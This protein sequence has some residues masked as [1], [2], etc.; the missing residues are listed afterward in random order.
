MLF[1]THYC[2]C[3]LHLIVDTWQKR[4]NNY[5][6]SYWIQK[7]IS[8]FE[9]CIFLV[10]ICNKIFMLAERGFALLSDACIFV[11]VCIHL[12]PYTVTL[13]YF[14][15]YSFI[16]SKVGP[17]WQLGFLVPFSEH[18]NNSMLYEVHLFSN[19]A[20]S[21][22]VVSRLKNL[23]AQLRQHRRHKIR[24]SVGKQR[25]RCHKLSAIEVD[26]FLKNM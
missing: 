13:Y 22:D 11:S 26:Y 3:H 19:G 6:P 16:T 2:I 23:K 4:E 12:R 18:T 14:W 1:Y 8:S 21:D 10:L 25:H 17:I 5:K 24:I 20:L 15:S 9:L 7:S